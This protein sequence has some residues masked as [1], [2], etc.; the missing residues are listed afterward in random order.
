MSRITSRLSPSMVVAA[1]ALFLAAGGSGYALG[2][3]T[4][5]Q[6][7]C[8]Q[9]AIRGIAI[10]TGD[11]HGIANLPS[12]FSADP[13]LFG[14]RFN[15]TGGAIQV[16]KS[17]SVPGGADIRFVGNAAANAIASVVGTGPGAA[18]VTRQPDGSF[19]VVTSIP[20]GD[21]PAPLN[22]TNTQFMIVLL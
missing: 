1:L 20:S 10:V 15:C 7:R 18:S 22:I 2:V 19:R 8:Q 14:Y 3:K 13:G 12:D 5:P 9:G 4:T 6:V 21:N 16:R 11:I 17:P